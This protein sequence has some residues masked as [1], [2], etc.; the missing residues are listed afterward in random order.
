LTSR[1]SCTGH[2][3]SFQARGRTSIRFALSHIIKALV[4]KVK[5]KR[6]AAILLIGI[7]LSTVM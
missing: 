4:Y 3:I 7:P 5:M 2:A 6:S 1:D